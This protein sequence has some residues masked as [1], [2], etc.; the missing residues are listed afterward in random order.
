MKSAPRPRTENVSQNIFRSKRQVYSLWVRDSSSTPIWQWMNL[1]SLDAPLLALVWQDFLARCYPSLLRPAGR[2]V[3]GLTVWGIYIA[4]RL[5]DVRSPAAEN[6]PIRHRFYRQNRGL[7]KVVLTSVV[8]ADLFIAL[9]WLRPAVFSNGMLIG[10]GVVC[11]LAVFPFSRM[12]ALKRWKRPCAALLFTTGIFLV[13]WTGT[14]NPWR[15]L[16]EPAVAFCALCL[17]NMMLIEWWEQGRFSARGWIWMLLLAALCT[18]P[19]H[20]RWYAAVA[21]A[22]LG[23]AAVD[24]CGGKLSQDARPLLADM[25]LFTPL[26]FR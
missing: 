24:L 15:V 12:A 4:D 14:V 23:L 13:A 26:L 2:W 22:A 20:E 9:L 25:L 8:F 6:E 17:G 21:A 16:G 5:I 18:L 3:L 19:G 7:A 1:F 10:A 11:Y